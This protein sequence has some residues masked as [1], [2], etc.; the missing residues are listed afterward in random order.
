M[1]KPRIVHTLTYHEMARRLLRHQTS[2]E[3]A[4]AMS[5]PLDTVKRIMQ[6]PAFKKVCLDLQEK[7]F[8]DVDR[9]LKA[10]ARNLHQELKQQAVKAYDLLKDM[11]TSAA[12]EGLRVNIAQDLMDRAGYRRTPEE[13]PTVVMNINPIDADVLATALAKEQKGRKALEIKELPVQSAR[14]LDHP[15]TRLVKQVERDERDNEDR[16]TARK[17]S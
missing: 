7:R 8:E 14:D 6:K 9:E 15:V 5:M 10:E 13:R 1:G 3:I 4:S 2:E 12:H 11:M 16:R 17:P